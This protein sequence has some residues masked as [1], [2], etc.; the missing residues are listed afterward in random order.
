MKILIADDE[1]TTR[2]IMEK[3]LSAY[4]DCDVVNNGLEAVDA[5]SE[6]IRSG[7][8]YDLVCLDIMMPI[9]DGHEVIRQIRKRE[10][11]AGLTKT[12]QAKI[13]MATSLRDAENIMTAMRAKANAY[14]VKPISVDKILKRLADIG[15]QVEA[16]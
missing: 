8:R 14:I 9:M 12:D 6:S 1:Q 4:G 3:T 2:I 11:D 15:I 13:I 16:R 7:Q 10:K 5:Y